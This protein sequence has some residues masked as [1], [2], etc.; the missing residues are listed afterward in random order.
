MMYQHHGHLPH[1]SC[2]PPPHSP[3]QWASFSQLMVLTYAAMPKMMASFATNATKH[4]A[5]TATPMSPPMNAYS[6][7]S[8]LP[9]EVLDDLPTEP[10]EMTC[11]DDNNNK[12]NVEDLNPL[13]VP[14]VHGLLLHSMET[15]AATTTNYRAMMKQKGSKCSQTIAVNHHPDTET[16]EDYSPCAP[17]KKL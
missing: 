13:E 3:S 6:Y 11:D 1:N 2:L 12:N 16:T 14:L 8:I 10:A 15:T 7:I 5:A 17:N 4:P 9:P